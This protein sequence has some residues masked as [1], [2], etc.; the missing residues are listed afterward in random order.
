MAA[1][2]K[3]ELEIIYFLFKDR[4]LLYAHGFFYVLLFLTL[5]ISME[6]IGTSYYGKYSDNFDT[7]IIIFIVATLLVQVILFLSMLIKLFTKPNT[8][9][10][11]SFLGL[12]IGIFVCFIWFGILIAYFQINDSSWGL[13]GL[14]FLLFSFLPCV[15]S[16]GGYILLIIIKAI[17]SGIYLLINKQNSEDTK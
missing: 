7:L 14:S 15:T 3:S 4:N 8:H 11:T 13:N 9:Q 10:L 17:R 12:F 5:R 16:I 2:K 6:F 1:Q